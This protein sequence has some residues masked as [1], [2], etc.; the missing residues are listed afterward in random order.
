MTEAADDYQYLYQVGDVVKV[1]DDLNCMAYPMRGESC[2]AIVAVSGMKKRAGTY[3]T[4]KEQ[5]E[6]LRHRCYRIKE[7]DCWWTD[8][9]FEYEEDDEKES[10]LQNTDND[11]EDFF[12]S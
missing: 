5:T 4:I 9:M 2:G 7:G 3:V 1:R 12:L 11:W 8:S 6:I 10:E